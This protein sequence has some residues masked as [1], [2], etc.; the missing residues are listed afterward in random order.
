LNTFKSSPETPGY[1][2]FGVVA[3]VASPA[4][5]HIQYLLQGASTVGQAVSEPL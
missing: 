5:C 4:Y 3:E 2:F 1:G